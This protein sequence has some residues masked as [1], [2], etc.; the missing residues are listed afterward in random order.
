MLVYRSADAGRNDW[1]AIE[2]L[3]FD[4]MPDVDEE[5]E[6]F[7]RLTRMGHYRNA[8]N[9]FAQ[10]LKQYIDQ[11]AV[12]IRYAEMLLDVED[13]RSIRLLEDQGDIVFPPSACYLEFL[14]DIPL[15]NNRDDD[16]DMYAL[17][18]VHIQWKLIYWIATSAGNQDGPQKILN[19]F[20]HPWITI[21][22]GWIIRAH[23]LDH[24]QVTFTFL[25][26]L[27]CLGSI[28]WL[29]LL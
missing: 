23:S 13:Y 9:Y 12:F 4:L 5:L 19:E 28:F 11:P 17:W 16:D 26:S 22:I 2:R 6:E 8:K 3:E 18:D 7:T 24:T 1:V 29:W 27:L 21:P 20:Q 14:Q 25:S 10:F 15:A